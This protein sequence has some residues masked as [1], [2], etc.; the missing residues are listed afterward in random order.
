MQGDPR[1]IEILNDVLSAELTAV[2]Q[3]FVHAKMQGNW[4]YTKLHDFT[5]AESIDEMRHAEMLMDR[6]LFLDGIPNV[7]RLYAVKVGEDVKEQFEV[8]LELEYVAIKRLNEGVAA[9]VAASDS[10]SREL[11]ERILV[12]EE[13]H[14]D[15]LEAQLTAIKQIGIE[16][17]LAQQLG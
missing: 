2:N 8:D 16:N 3:Y 1:V 4:G 6:I 11:L 5:R 7:Q 10:G 14:T 9:C 15:W 17:Y 12:S 13:E